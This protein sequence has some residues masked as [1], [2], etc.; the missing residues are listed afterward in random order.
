MPATTAGKMLP[1]AWARPLKKKAQKVT[2]AAARERSRLI[3]R[4]A[5]GERLVYPGKGAPAMGAG[6]KA[7]GDLPGAALPAPLSLL[8]RRLVRRQRWAVPQVDPERA[9]V[10]EEE[11][12]QGE[13]RLD[14]PWTEHA[15]RRG[16]R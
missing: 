13:G 4:E 16:D 7:C 14:R 5:S 10:G 9:R 6:E 8:E 11:R 1:S 12:V 2:S 3:I 15:R